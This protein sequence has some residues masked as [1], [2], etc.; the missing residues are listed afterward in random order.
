MLRGKVL[1]RPTVA[2]FLIQQPPQSEISK[3]YHSS[4]F[5]S[6]ILGNYEVLNHLKDR[7]L[8]LLEQKSI[9]IGQH[10]S[11]RARHTEEMRIRGEIY[12]EIERKQR[13]K[14]VDW[15]KLKA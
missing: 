12:I 9:L 7:Y 15:L 8:S 5:G 6:L 4:E 11:R 10:Q 2:G 3:R 1:L 13:K 14:I